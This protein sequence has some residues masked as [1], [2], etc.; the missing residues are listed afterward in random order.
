M[1]LDGLVTYVLVLVKPRVAFARLRERPM[2]GWAALAGLALTLGAVLIAEP[3][4]MHL[5]SLSEAHRIAVLPPG[6]RLQERIAAA[7]V[8][9]LRHSLFIVGALTL[10][11]ITWFL[12]A[13]FFFIAATVS[14]GRTSF[15]QA[16]VAA[17]NSYAVYGVAGI[18]NAGLVA[19][20][21]PATI[22][23]PLDLVMVPSL[24]WLVPHDAALAA[25]LS[26]YTVLNVW[27]YVVVAFALIQLLKMSNK[28]AIAATVGYSLLYGFFAASVAG[29]GP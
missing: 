10:P 21:N 29:R 25:F 3:A 9:G 18:V 28:A 5:L 4:Q 13:L 7:Q 14:R 8:A 27:Y 1:S 24:A 2:W 22:K 15:G 26:A 17:L 23:S 20:R 19:L 12:I 16:W 6:E 11:W